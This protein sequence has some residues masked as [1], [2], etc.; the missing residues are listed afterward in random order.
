MILTQETLHLRRFLDETCSWFACSVPG[1]NRRYNKSHGY[2]VMKEGAAEDETNKQLAGDFLESF[3]L[4][5][6]PLGLTI[7]GHFKQN[8]NGLATWGCVVVWTCST[9]VVIALPSLHK[10]TRRE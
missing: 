8:R 6:V 3:C 10:M 1:C 7:R 9:R 2:Y 4:R 5:F